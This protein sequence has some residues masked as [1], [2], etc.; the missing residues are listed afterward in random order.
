M[1]T[2][3]GYDET[4]KVL[5][6]DPYNWPLDCAP[7][8]KQTAKA[9]ETNKPEDIARSIDNWCWQQSAGVAHYGIDAGGLGAYALVRYRNF[10]VGREYWEYNTAIAL[11]FT[12][13]LPEDRTRA[14]RTATEW[15]ENLNVGRDYMGYRNHDPASEEGARRRAKAANVPLEWQSGDLARVWEFLALSDYP[16]NLD[17]HCGPDIQQVLENL[18]ARQQGAPIPW[19]PIARS[20]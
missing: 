11:G 15:A 8:P 1:R 19:L 17:D 4:L 5:R 13:E 12:H 18:W 2:T 7:A 6:S 9:L 10:S 20:N 14:A 16:A 3:P